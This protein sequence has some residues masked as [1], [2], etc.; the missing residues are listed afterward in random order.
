MIHVLLAFI[1]QKTAKFLHN[2]QRKR[3]NVNVLGVIKGWKA[4]LRVLDRGLL[5]FFEQ[6]S[7]IQDVCKGI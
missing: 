7:R 5:V 4:I 2:Q 3:K 6:N 1:L